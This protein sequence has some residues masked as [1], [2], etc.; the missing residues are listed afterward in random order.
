MQ[1]EKKSGWVGLAVVLVLAGGL[2]LRASEMPAELGAGV[3]VLNCEGLA[4]TVMVLADRA[5]PIA[6]AKNWDGTATFAAAGA[7]YGNGRAIYLGHPSF[8]TSAGLCASTQA[9][10]RNAVSW[11]AKSARK[12]KVGVFRNDAIVGVLRTVSIEATRFDDLASLGQYDVV[13]SID[14]SVETAPAY[15]DYVR[16]GGGLLGAGLGWG[17]KQIASRTR[18]VSFADDFG[19][20]R[21]Y[22]PMGILMGAIGIVRPLENGFPLDTREV[23]YGTRADDALALA[24]KGDY[25]DKEQQRQV[26]VVLS[27]MAAVLPPALPDGIRERMAA[28]TRHP[29]AAKVPSPESPVEPED[30]FARLAILARKADY[31]CDRLKAWPADAAAAVY[32]GLVKPGTPTVARAVEIDASIPRWHSTGLFAPAGRTISFAFPEDA[33][34][35]N[36]RLRIG[37]TQDDLSGA[38]K[39]WRRF[40]LVT[41]E[42]P[43]TASRAE[44]TSPFGGLIYVVVPDR[45][46]VVGRKF[47]VRIDGGVMAPWFKSGR[48]TAEDFRAQCETT[49]APQGEIEGKNFI[50]T[51]ETSGLRQCEDPQWV[52]DYWDRYLDACQWLAALPPRHYPERLCSDIQLQGA[53]VLHDGYPMMA[54]VDHRQPFASVLDRTELARGRL[55][56]VYHEIGHNH[57]NRDWTPEGTSEVTVNIFSLMAINR[58]AGRNFRDPDFASARA[59]TDAKVRQWVASGKTFELWKKDPF[60]A[61]EFYTRLIETYGWDT[62][63]EVFAAYRRPGFSRPRT[64][65]EKWD[66][67]ARTFSQTAKTDMAAVMRAWNLPV[68][69][70]VCAD[71]ASYPASPADLTRGLERVAYQPLATTPVEGAYMGVCLKGEDVGAIELYPTRTD[72]PCGEKADR[73][74]GDWLLL[75][76]IEPT[77]GEVTMGNPG[78]T[79]GADA[80]HGVTLTAPYYIGVYELTQQQWFNVMGSWKGDTFGDAAH[81][82]FKPVNGVAYCHTRGNVTDGINWPL[83]GHEVSPDSFFGRLRELTGFRADFD[84]PTEAQWEWACRAGAKGPWGTGEDPLPYTVA[85]AKPPVGAKR[86]RVLDTLGRYAGNNVPPYGPA[87][88][89]SYR[90]NLWGLYDMH[91]NVFE[92]CLDYQNIET[93]LADC[94]GVDP[95]GPADASRSRKGRRVMKGGSVLCYGDPGD[96]AAWGRRLGGKTAPVIGHGATGCRICVSACVAPAP[97]L[98]PWAEKLTAEQLADRAAL[99][100]GTRVFAVKSLAGAA[101]CVETNAFPLFSARHWDRTPACMAVAARFGKGRVV[102]IADDSGALDAVENAALKRNFKT[103]L[104]ANGPLRHVDA[105]GLQTVDPAETVAFVRQGG[106]LLVTANG[107]RWWMREMREKGR[108]SVSDWPGNALL[109]NFGILAGRFCV[110]RTSPGGFLTQMMCSAGAAAARPDLFETQHYER[111]HAAAPTPMRAREGGIRVRDGETIAFLGDSITRLGGGEKGYISLVLKALEVAGV[112]NVQAVR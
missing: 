79:T 93:S 81:R 53:G 12:P 69:E 70:K 27:Q 60:L 65:A 104:S 24:A 74:K 50:V 9:F 34:K 42:A 28:F 90:P 11:L 111:P 20:N 7:E 4:G 10:H 96:C 54:L 102:F 94:S 100:E 19:D 30:V 31:E 49:G 13:A 86:D 71:C 108:A 67:F 89:G 78:L 22:G 35:W 18:A 38:A 112:R 36:L 75:R 68:S 82:A 26:S 48:D 63:A 33:G 51:F 66:V 76:R 101:F 25:K 8:L 57:Q 103:W 21:V 47:T 43:V 59:G 14:F 72:I 5:F 83:S 92:H 73:W 77:P 32:P 80:C 58:I 61:L 62:L 45:G 29:D 105:A 87:A 17:W 110:R 97:Q 84:L 41:T 56:G 39:G 88:V 16:R 44:L 98:A 37:T 2:S 23:P 6:R 99:V 85:D 52:A 106:G 46:E 40:P 1:K 91:G 64:D 107:W 15:L 95:V 3:D 55:W 109:E